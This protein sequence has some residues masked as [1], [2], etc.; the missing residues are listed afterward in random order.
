MRRTC[1]PRPR[2][3]GRGRRAHPAAL[4]RRRPDARGAARHARPRGAVLRGVLRRLR[5]RPGARCCSAPSRRSRATTRSCCCATSASRAIASTTWC[6]SSAG[7]TSPTCRNNRVVGIS[8][9]ARVVD[10]YAKRLQIQEKLTAQIANTIDDV[11]QP[12]GV[13]VVIE[14]AHQCMTTRGVHKPGRQHGDQPDARRLPRRRGNPARGDGDDRP[15]VVLGV[16]DLTG[17]G[18][19]ASNAP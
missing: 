19:A 6:R 9:L 3:G 15:A 13:A 12:R 4:G 8:K 7:P 10:A 2:R 17:D 11:L 18:A 14:A 16:R 1:A 5:H